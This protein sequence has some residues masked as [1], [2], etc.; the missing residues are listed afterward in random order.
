MKNNEKKILGKIILVAGLLMGCSNPLEKLLEDE[1]GELGEAFGINVKGNWVRDCSIETQLKSHIEFKDS[2]FT[3]I[4]T[5]Y[6]ADCQTK[7]STTQA[8]GNYGIVYNATTSQYE[9]ELS[10]YDIDVTLNAEEAVEIYNN[11]VFCGNDEWQ[12]NTQVF[13]FNESICPN[14][15]TETLNTPLKIRDDDK[16]LLGKNISKISTAINSDLGSF[17]DNYFIRQ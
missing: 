3:L 5:R 2:T 6:S 13:L 14:K 11:E 15:I 10:N 8:Q 12:L 7:E 17:D 4:N 1:F 9:T 16:L